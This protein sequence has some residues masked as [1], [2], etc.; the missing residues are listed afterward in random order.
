MFTLHALCY[1]VNV[2]VGISTACTYCKCELEDAPAKIKSCGADLCEV[3]LNTFSEYRA[4]YVDMLKTRIDEQ[5]LK[6]TSIH[7]MS[8]QFEAQLFALH[9]RQREDAVDIYKSVLRAGKTLGAKIYVMH[10]SP[11]LSG[12]AKNLQL[13]RLAPLFGEYVSM[14]QDYGIQLTLENVSWCFFNRPDFGLE[15]QQAMGDHSLKFTLD[16]KQAIRSGFDPLLFVE[17]VGR[18]MVHLHLCDYTIS[19]G[20]L[21]L[22]MPGHGDFDFARLKSAMLE[23][24]FSG[25]A[26]LEVYSDMYQGFDELGAAYRYVLNILK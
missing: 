25:D 7:P 12:A 5:G 13:E 20:G 24:G 10:G 15:L 17:S 1:N 9:H 2:R 26:M 8:A 6:V 11:H 22:Q 19:D 21:K 18:D 16:I 3:F 4:V 14:A 23:K